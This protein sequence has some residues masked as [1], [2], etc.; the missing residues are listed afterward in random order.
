MIGP[1]I[2]CP[3]DMDDVMISPWHENSAVV[4]I[5]ADDARVI[6][7]SDNF[8]VEVLRTI[9]MLFPPNVRLNDMDFA[10]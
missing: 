8:T 7:N 2:T 1:T 4:H 5:S 6:E 9:S 3:D 10:A